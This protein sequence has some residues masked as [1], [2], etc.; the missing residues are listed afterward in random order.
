MLSN[1]IS[2]TVNQPV[3]GIELSENEI[4]LSEIGSS[5]QLYAKIT[6]DD[7]TNKNVNWSSSNENICRVSQTGLVTATGYGTSVIFATTEEKGYMASCVVT[8]ESIDGINNPTIGTPY[9]IKDNS[10]FVKEQYNTDYTIVSVDGKLIHKG[11]EQKITLKSG[12][13]ILYINRKRYKINI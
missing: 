8:V 7:A 4:K 12:I 13:Y 6:P 10:L 9:Y 2:V 1:L 3:T 5:V 11:T